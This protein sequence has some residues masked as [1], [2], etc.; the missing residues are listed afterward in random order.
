MKEELGKKQF[1]LTPSH[2]CSYLPGRQARTLFLDPRETIHP[3]LYQALTEHGFRRSGSHLYRPRC[4]GCQ[5]CVPTR[6]PVAAFVPRRSQRR[7]LSRNA[8]L[9]V[10]VEPAMFSRRYY[11]LYV[12]YIQGRHRDGD[13]YPPSADQFRSFLLSQW[14]NGVFLCSYLNNE[15]IAVAVCDQLPDGL[16]AIYT[17]FDPEHPARSLGTWSILQQIELCRRS[18]LTH[19]YLGYWIRDA[20]KMRYK[21]DFRPVEL[22]V[23]GRWT[24]LY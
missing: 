2:P 9:S 4:D 19:L 7:V 23:D 21:L 5:A 1:Y 16:S 3:S 12:R 11:D 22:F 13:M 14:A 8:D 10:H 17:F 15:L 20:R 24:G 6:I 18:E